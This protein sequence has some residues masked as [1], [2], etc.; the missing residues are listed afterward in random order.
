MYD[1]RCRAANLS[2]QR[3]YSHQKSLT[4][5]FKK[6]KLWDHG[7]FKILSSNDTGKNNNQA[8]PVIPIPIHQYLPPIIEKPTVQKPAVSIPLFVE[9]WCG[10]EFLSESSVRYQIQSW[11]TTVRKNGQYKQERRI[12]R[13]IRELMDK[14]EPEDLLIMQRHLHSLSKYRLTLIRKNDA[15]FGRIIKN[16]INNTCGPVHFNLHP[17][18]FAELERQA[19]EIESEA[20]SK[21]FD[22]IEANPSSNTTLVTKYC[23]EKVFRQKVLEIYQYRCAACRRGLMSATGLIEVDA[24]HIIPRSCAGANDARNGIALCKSHHWAFDKG[25]FWI[26]DERKIQVP[27]EIR[28]MKSNRHLSYLHGKSLM[29]PSL[30]ELAPH[31]RALQWHRNTFGHDE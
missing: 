2:Q 13:N 8:G 19:K 11:P 5:M 7:F 27:K 10:S 23:R 12:T 20:E 14:A 29:P 17:E 1:H 9:L 6:D 15:L 31:S 18:S 30:I 4:N 24:A 3:F 16:V 22:P 25:L 28:E 21:E 26:N